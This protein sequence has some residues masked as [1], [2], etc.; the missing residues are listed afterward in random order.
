MSSHHLW[1]LNRDGADFFKF[2]YLELDT[3]TITVNSFQAIIARVF[4]RLEQLFSGYHIWR[5]IHGFQVISCF[6]ARVSGDGYM[7]LKPS[8][9]APLQRWFSCFLGI[10]SCDGFMVF[11]GSISGGISMVFKTFIHIQ[12]LYSCF[13][14]CISGDGYL[15]F[16]PSS[17][18]PLQR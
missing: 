6:Q 15:I 11:K 18:T 1:H 13:Q 5:L 16:M 14:A 12:I 2:P 7:V 9:L 17:M 4:T 10:I 8:F 3:V